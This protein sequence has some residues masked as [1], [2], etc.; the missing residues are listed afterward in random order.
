MCQHE[1]YKISEILFN[2]FGKKIAVLICC[3]KCGFQQKNKF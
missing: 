3:L 1:K 2:K